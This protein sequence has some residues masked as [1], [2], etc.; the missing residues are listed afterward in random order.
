MGLEEVMTAVEEDIPVTAIVFNNQ[1]WGAEKRNQID[2]YDNRF[3]GT[4]I[5]RDSGGFNF[6]EIATAMKASSRRVE[7]SDELKDAYMWALGEDAPVV[8]EVMVD[9]EELAEP[10]RRDALKAPRRLLEKYSHLDLTGSPRSTSS[11]DGE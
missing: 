10:F 6:A 8:L 9:P 4:N 11:S 2:F 5:G 3:V 7:S 1:Q